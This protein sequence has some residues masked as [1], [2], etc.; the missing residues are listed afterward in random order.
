MDKF[1]PRLQGVPEK[2]DDRK[3]PEYSKFL[4]FLQ[5][6]RSCCIASA[7]HATHRTFDLQRQCNNFLKLH[8]HRKQKIA[9]V[10]AALSVFCQH[11][12]SSLSYTIELTMQITHKMSLSYVSLS[13]CLLHLNRITHRGLSIFGLC[14]H[15]Y[16]IAIFS[17]ISFVIYFTRK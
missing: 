15:T 9:R 2:S 5:F 8:C 12:L 13:S 7:K 10:A 14:K 4:M 16:Q 3:L 17:L 11:K 1:A 6:F